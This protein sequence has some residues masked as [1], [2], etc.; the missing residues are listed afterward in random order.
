MVPSFFTAGLCSCFWS[1]PAEIIFNLA[2]APE[3]PRDASLV[4]FCA[5]NKNDQWLNFPVSMFPDRVIDCG[6]LSLSADLALHACTAERRKVYCKSFWERIFCDSISSDHRKTGLFDKT[7][8]DDAI[9]SIYYPS[10]LNIGFTST[11]RISSSTL[12]KRVLQLSCV[13]QRG[14]CPAR[15]FDLYRCGSN[16]GR[17]CILYLAHRVLNHGYQPV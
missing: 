12:P 17:E 2:R 5:V 14:S 3:V 15:E 9:D 11:S 8:C 13:P 4:R 16:S 6:T 7:P 10:S 1:V